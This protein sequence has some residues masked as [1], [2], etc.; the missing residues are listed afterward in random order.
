MKKPI[1]D[2][3]Q[4]T[5]A[6][7]TTGSMVHAMEPPKTVQPTE[8]AVVSET[9]AEEPKKVEPIKKPE[10]PPVA[11]V[12]PAPPVP[13]PAPVPPPTPAP[14]VSSGDCASELGK[15]DWPQAAAYKVMMRESTNNPRVIN[16]N[17]RTGDYS[18]G[19]FQI[20]L[21]GGMRYTRPSEAS[22]LI[23]E[24]NVRFAY[25]LWV[26]QGRSFCTTG[27]W[28]NTCIAVGLR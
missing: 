17:P 19:C 27:G 26:S 3:L 22:L 18:V 9:K 12:E 4:I 23:A 1:K 28:L 8:Q 25:Q 6:L 2:M 13:A 11:V 14:V 24:N 7:L 21:I 10:T 15:Y 16:N 20:N 5:V